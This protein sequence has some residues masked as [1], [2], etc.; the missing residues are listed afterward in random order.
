[1]SAGRQWKSEGRVAANGKRVLTRMWQ[2]PSITVSAVR[3]C[4]TKRREQMS[5]K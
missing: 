4:L 3:G 2:A 5:G 1:M